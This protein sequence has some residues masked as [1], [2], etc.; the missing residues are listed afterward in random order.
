[1]STVDPGLTALGSRSVRGLEARCTG[2]GFRQCHL[3]ASCHEGPPVLQ[4]TV[5]SKYELQPGQNSR[6]FIRAPVVMSAVADVVIVQ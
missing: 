2:S 6:S 3:I 5:T 1:M 4:M